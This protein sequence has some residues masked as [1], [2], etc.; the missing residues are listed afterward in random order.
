[1]VT[2]FHGAQKQ[3]FPHHSMPPEAVR[4]ALVQAGITAVDILPDPAQAWQALL[5]RPEPILLVTGS[6]YLMNHIRPLLRK[7]S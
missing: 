5:A 6:F 7:L 1:V 4:T 3:D 2:S